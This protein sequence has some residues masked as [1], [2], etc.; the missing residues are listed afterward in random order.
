LFYR[1]KPTVSAGQRGFLSCLEAVVIVGTERNIPPN[2]TY[3]TSRIWPLAA[4]P[5]VIGL[6]DTETESNPHDEHRGNRPKP[7]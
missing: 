3:I 7:V 6:V 2:V 4:V 5:P 1:D